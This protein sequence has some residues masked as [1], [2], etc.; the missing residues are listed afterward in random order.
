MCCMPEI[1]S[2]ID[3]AENHYL[4]AIFYWV[5]IGLSS[6]WPERRAPSS[7][8]AGRCRSEHLLVP[9]A[10]MSKQVLR[11]AARVAVAKVR[12]PPFRLRVPAQAARLAGD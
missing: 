11:S 6:S 12:P 1:R 7:P 10:M 3:Q 2:E 5:Q 8:S 9:P 4:S